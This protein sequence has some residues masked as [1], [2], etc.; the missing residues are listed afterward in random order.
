MTAQFASS[1]PTSPPE[2][3]NFKGPQESLER[4]E[5]T[6]QQRFEFKQTFNPND[7]R[8]KRGEPVLGWS[9]YLPQHWMSQ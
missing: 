9:F 4:G 2:N 3:A 7:R 8:M 6:C 1:N 5:T